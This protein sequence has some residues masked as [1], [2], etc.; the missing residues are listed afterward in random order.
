MLN[1]NKLNYLYKKSFNIIRTNNILNNIEEVNI[2]EDNILTT[3]S[4]I[5]SQ[6]DINRDII[7]NKV[8]SELLNINIDDNNNNIIGSLI[9]KTSND[10]L[11]KKYVKIKLNYVPNSEIL[12]NNNNIIGITFFSDKMINSIPYNFDIEGSYIYELYRPD[13][14]TIINNE[15]G[16]WYID[17]ESGLLVFNSNINNNININN[18]NYIN[19]DNTPTITF[20]CYNGKI[21]LYPLTYNKSDEITIMSN[22]NINNNLIIKENLISSNLYLNDINYF[23]NININNILINK[24]NELYFGAN[25]NWKKI[26]K[27]GSLISTS[28]EYF[29]YDINNTILDNTKNISLIDISSSLLSDIN[30]IL[31]DVVENGIEKTIMIG[32][33]IINYINNYNI[34]L[35]GEFIDLNGNG[36]DKMNIYFNKTGQFIKLISII[37]NNPNIIG[38][39]KK[40]WQIIV[41]NSDKITTIIDNND[42]YINNFD[43]LTYDNSKLNILNINTSITFIELDNNINNDIFIIL[44]E[45]LTSGIKK[46]IVCGESVN[47]YLDN[48][49]NIIIY[50]TFID[51]SGIG[52]VKMNLKFYNTGQLINII[53]VVDTNNI[54][55]W[56]IINGHFDCTDIFTFQNNIF[57][58]TSNLNSQIDLITSHLQTITSDNIIQ[59]LLYDE[60]ILPINIS[61]YTI[62]TTL[63][64]NIIIIQ[65]SDYLTQNVSLILQNYNHNGKESII[66][67]G[68]YIN[69]Y[70]NGYE[71][72]LNSKFITPTNNGPDTFDI[73]FTKSGNFIQLMSVVVKNQNIYLYSEKYWIIITSSFTDDNLNSNY[74]NSNSLNQQSNSSISVY[75]KILSFN[76]LNII[77]NHTTIIEL[78]TLC[79]TDIEIILPL[80]IYPGIKYYIIMGESINKYINNNKIILIG[81]F[82]Y[83]N[84]TYNNLYFTNSGQYI[85]LLSIINSLNDINQTNQDKY[86]QI[87]NNNYQ[88]YDNYTIDINKSTYINNLSLIQINNFINTDY[89]LISPNINNN[90]TIIDIYKNFTIIDITQTL[91]NDIY[92]I[93]PLFDDYGKKKLISLSNT[94]YQYLNNKNIYIYSIFINRNNIIDKYIIQL[95]QRNPLIKLVSIKTINNIGFTYQLYWQIIT[96]NISNINISNNIISNNFDYIYNIT[97]NIYINIPSYNIN[98]DFL[99]NIIN[100]NNLNENSKIFSYNHN[101]TNIIPNDDDDII[102]LELT[103]QLTHDAYII[104][105][106]I[107]NIG[108]QKTI[109]TGQSVNNF[110][111]GYNI[112]LYSNYININSIGPIFINIKF[113]NSGQIINIISSIT[114]KYNDNNINYW[115][116]LSGHFLNTDLTMTNGIIMN[117]NQPPDIIKRSFIYINDNDN[118]QL[119][120]NNIELLNT[121][122][123][124]YNN[125]NINLITTNKKTTIIELTQYLT[126]DIFIILPNINDI[127]FYKYIL[128]GA[129]VSKYINNYNIIIYSKYI[130]PDG[131]G[132]IFINIKMNMSGQSLYLVSLKKNSNNIDNYINYYWQLINGHFFVDDNINFMD[133]HIY[134]NYNTNNTYNSLVDPLYN[135]TQNIN[136][137][138]YP[139]LNI[140]KNLIS[141]LINSTQI[142]ATQI[143][144]N[145]II[146][147]NINIQNA[148][149]HD[150]KIKNYISLYDTIY[151]NYIYTINS[152]YKNSLIILKLN[153]NLTQNKVLTLD[154]INTIGLKK[155]IIFDDTISTYTN[156]YIIEIKS[157]FLGS[158]NNNDINFNSDNFTSI[159]TISITKSGQILNLISMKSENNFNYWFIL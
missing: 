63:Y 153:S 114:E 116:I 136:I 103:Q 75:K 19:K 50:G 3:K 95:S 73:E 156:N 117:Y 49:K 71:I 39:Y 33:S 68:K 146:S 56:Q 69:T 132:P 72:I 81:K 93:L 55:Y 158:I 20:Y 159:S 41:D 58:N 127:G 151:I 124:I 128:L 57:Y 129:S 25:G 18:I 99:S 27:E 59:N 4:K 87:I 107:N 147:N 91:Y 1:E 64:K 23:P 120:Y 11:I 145:S 141:P 74:N 48:N 47:K 131:T 157:N 15:E 67:M 40:Y 16:D 155:T 83:D 28:I 88:H 21:G 121:Q 109:I 38:S 76:T 14:N 150:L 111:N 101:I 137:I 149:I 80:I 78:N 37:T 12:D 85:E 7:P 100:Q 54:N 104:L 125:N 10:N 79:Y 139:S 113:T 24:S 102:I 6:R 2:L 134:I 31:P 35:E 26:L 89:E 45:I 5:F 44:P 13:N 60:I 29:M 43:I 8:P 144:C 119:N 142:N 138:A 30:I 90:F 112:I 118:V 82:I 92:F 22:L 154:T 61:E 34:I 140:I 123:L 36:P 126:S 17:N 148:T 84:I 94:T 53:S 32:H 122:V 46:L 143:N 106:T 105:P 135:I 97:N 52:P 65:L 77:T 86:W 70:I 108:Q 130:T 133:N 66:I 110:I 42:L 115:Q 62:D 51:I 96:N 98:Y 152:N 9:G